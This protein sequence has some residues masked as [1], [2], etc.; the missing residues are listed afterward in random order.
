M[1][2]LLKCISDYFDLNNVKEE[3]KVIV[4]TPHIYDEYY[5]NFFLTALNNLGVN[6]LHVRVPPKKKDIGLRDLHVN[7]FALSDLDINVLK[8]ADL[9]LSI[10]KHFQIHEH[11]WFSMY[12]PSFRKLQEEG[13]RWIDFMIGNPEVNFPRLYP[14]EAITRRASG[15]TDVASKA[16]KIRITSGAGTDVTMEKKEGASGTPGYLYRKRRWA[17]YGHAMVTMV[18]AGETMNGVIV[19]DTGDYLL[20]MEKTVT[21]PV[22]LTFKNGFV[23]KID[24]GLTAEQ[25]KMWLDRY[26]D[27]NVYAISHIGWGIHDGAVWSDSIW[28]TGADAESYMGNM[29]FALGDGAYRHALAHMDIEL[30]NCNYYLDDELIV[31]NGKIVHPR[32]K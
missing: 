4:L 28:F 2:D 3:N 17:N 1:T 13:P 32:C 8:C 31:A 21:E 15:G 30:L 11:P 23:T 25:L 29:Q 12:N 27:P 16:K 7:L 6:Y 24:G 10:R 26:D 20:K 5:M 18:P 9:I 19:I 22:R 14:T